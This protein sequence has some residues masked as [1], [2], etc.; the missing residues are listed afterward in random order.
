MFSWLDRMDLYL[1]PSRQEGLPR[2]LIEAMSRGLPA[3]GSTIAGIHELLEKECL[4]LPN[5]EKMLADLILK[6]LSDKQWLKNQAARNYH[7]AKSYSKSNLDLI[8]TEFWSKFAESVEKQ[9]HKQ[10]Q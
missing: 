1:Q 9:K 7:I 6:A 5:D 4:H 10:L 3:I 8:R 2:A